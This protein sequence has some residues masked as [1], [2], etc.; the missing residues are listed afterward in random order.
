MVDNTIR[1]TNATYCFENSE[2]QCGTEAGR[3]KLKLRDGG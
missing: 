3:L 2:T 1:K